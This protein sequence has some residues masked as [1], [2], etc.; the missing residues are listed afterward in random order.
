MSEHHKH[1]VFLKRLIHCE[2]TEECRQL[3][4]RLGQAEREEH[5]VRCAITLMAFLTGLSVAGLAYAAVLLPDF[6]YNKSQ[7]V[8]RLFLAFGLASLICLVT[9]AGLWVRCR[10]ILNQLHDE[11]RELVNAALERGYEKLRTI[12]F[13]RTVKEQHIALYQNETL[14]GEGSATAARLQKAR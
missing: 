11:C 7:F 4:A 8:L 12:P 14:A 5:V 9:F 13:P 10:R 1:T 2:E 3:E 6:P